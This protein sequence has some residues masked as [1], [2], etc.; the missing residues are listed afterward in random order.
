MIR[1]REPLPE[2]T[3]DQAEVAT[4]MTLLRGK[5]AQEVIQVGGEV[6]PGRP[7]Q[8]LDQVHRRPVVRPPRRDPPI[9]LDLARHAGSSPSPHRG[10]AARAACRAEGG[11]A[12]VHVDVDRS[13]PSPTTAVVRRGLRLGQGTTTP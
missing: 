9:G 5:V 1:S 3:G 6:V 13:R 4:V 11:H 2:L 8:M 12:D 10:S 7:G